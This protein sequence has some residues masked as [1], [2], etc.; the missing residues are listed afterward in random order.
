MRLRIRLSSVLLLLA[1]H[2]FAQ[3]PQQN[4]DSHIIWKQEIKG[5]I[6][7]VGD[8]ATSDSSGDLWFMSDPFDADP[9][10]VHVG[11]SGRGVS[12]DKLPD[13]IHPR[14]PEVSSFA[15]ASSTQGNIGIL[16]SH[17]HMIGKTIYNDGAD[18]ALFDGTK[19]GLPVKVAGSGPEYNRLVVFSDNHFLAMGDQGPMALVKFD[20]AG[21]IDWRRRFPWSWDLPSGASLEHGGACILSSGY[22]VPWMHLMKL[23]DAG[24]MRS[25]IKFQGWNGVISADPSDSCVALYST[26]SPKQ[27]RVRFHLTSFDSSLRQKWSTAM[28]FDSPWGGSF[29]L[30]SLKD[31][32]VV[33]VESD[34]KLGTFFIAKFDFSGSIVWSLAD[35][36]IPP[37]NLVV[38]AGDSF[39]VV[40]T[41]TEDR[42]SSIVLR[43]K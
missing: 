13:A 18:F 26:G 17:S 19:L 4:L 25:Q 23:D 32:W 16:V 41:E 37:P 31:G 5:A 15:L 3:S 30:V 36:A 39:Y 10:L 8:Q 29:Y 42:H 12:V 35:A 20:M 21:K 2:L 11:A 22:G 27:N 6:A 33:V 43:V 28:P 38:G 1:G 34:A 40:Y 14:F 7:S 9:R 24:Q